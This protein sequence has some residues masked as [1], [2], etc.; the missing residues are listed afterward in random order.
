MA[1][2]GEKVGAPVVGNA[3][4]YFVIWWAGRKGMT[5]DDPVMAALMAGA[6]ITWIGLQLRIVIHWVAGLI[7]REPK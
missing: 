2:Q 6:I 1:N 3:F 5:F 4:A 7:K